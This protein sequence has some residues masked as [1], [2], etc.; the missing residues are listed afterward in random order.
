MNLEGYCE[1]AANATCQNRTCP[2]I[3][4]KVR[5]DISDVLEEQCLCPT[6]SYFT[7]ETCQ[8]CPPLTYGPNCS[9]ACNCDQNNTRYCNR[10]T[11]QCICKSG[12]TSYHC[13]RDVNECA[14][15]SNPCPEFSSCSNLNGSYECLC[16]EGLQRDREGLCDAKNDSICTRRNCSHV[17]AKIKNQDQSL[18]EHCYC[19]IGT[20]PI[21]DICQ[22]LP[23][24]GN[25]T[26]GQ[27]CNA[28]CDCVT[29]NTASCNPVNGRC[30]CLLGWT[31]NACELDVN[32]CYQYNIYCDSY[33]Q[34]VNTPGS[35]ECV[36]FPGYETGPY[37][38][39]VKASCNKT[40]SNTTGVIKSPN[41]PVKYFDNTACSWTIQ[42]PTGHV[43]SLRF[44]TF[45]LERQQK[46]TYDSLSFYDGSSSHVR[47]IGVYCGLRI[48]GL[49]RTHGNN[50]YIAFKG[51][52]SVT[53]MGFYA[54]YSFHVCEDFT[55]GDTC[56]MRCS[57][58]RNNTQFCDNTNG[59]CVCKPGW[60]GGN[61][62][63]DIDECQ[64]RNCQDNEV[65]ENSPG[66]FLCTCKP[67]YTKN[68]TGLCEALSN[69]KLK[70]CSHSCY[71]MSP[72]VEQCMCPDGLILDKAE[73]ST[74]VVPFYPYG[75]TAND[76]VLKYDMDVDRL[77]DGT[78]VSKP[79]YYNTGVPIGRKNYLDRVA[80]VFSTGA[81]KFGDAGIPGSPDLTAASEGNHSLF[82]PYWANM[83]PSKGSTFH[84]LYERCDSPRRSEIL[85][86]A[87]EEITLFQ[88]FSAFN[89][90]S[91][92]VVTWDSVQPNSVSNR[93]DEEITFQ[94]VLIS[95]HATETINGQV[96]F[97]DEETSYLMFIYQ[98]GALNW[99]Y[100]YN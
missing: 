53:F 65:C 74:C 44:F 80:Y 93:T 49:I 30:T 51:D 41:Y 100:V 9:Y 70:N 39:C 75:F 17:C 14:N 95:G 61:C 77:P 37:E 35:Y 11:G 59:V 86:R 82:A 19:P 72:G 48:P 23:G 10:T 57:C 84:H 21:G 91:V 62:S 64:A 60:M 88:K 43:I 13:S 32:E 2:D 5:S 3:C 85:K 55:Y 31:S 89:V 7:N 8:A 33:S 73:H 78:L 90:S 83:D 15:A 20:E 99:K 36:C 81:F 94:A 18:V 67:E 1:V 79:I 52:G 96:V 34:C 28:K 76:N 24:C 58:D 46:C 38:N 26:Y 92:F 66:S 50:L 63:I 27:D 87:E 40:L 29:E 4:V 42:A 56:S 47:N 25:G 71:I 68:I 6:G 45:A 97:A 22:I 54:A 16:Y 12:W 69:C 98:L